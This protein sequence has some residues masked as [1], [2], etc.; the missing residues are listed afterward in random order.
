MRN[1][2]QERFKGKMSMI[3]KEG[4]DAVIKDSDNPILKSEDFQNDVIT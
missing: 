3:P 1:A 2:F 4:V